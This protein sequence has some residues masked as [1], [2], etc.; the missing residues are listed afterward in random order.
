VLFATFRR[1]ICS[2]AAGSAVWAL[3]HDR[4]VAR[5]AS[6]I[7]IGE[8]GGPHRA[9]EFSWSANEWSLHR[10]TWPA[11]LVVVA[12]VRW[13]ARR[14]AANV[15]DLRF[16]FSIGTAAFTEFAFTGVAARKGFGLIR[17][18][19][20][21]GGADFIDRATIDEA[22]STIRA[23]ATIAAAAIAKIAATLSVLGTLVPIGGSLELDRWPAATIGNR[24]CFE[25][26]QYSGA[27]A[28]FDKSKSRTV[29]VACEPHAIRQRLPA[30]GWNV[31]AVF[32]VAIVENIGFQAQIHRWI[33]VGD[34]RKFDALCVG[35]R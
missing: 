11:D 6:A 20:I 35:L 4:A 1:T 17:I 27:F 19:R 3:P 14:T 18:L 10:H 33:Y 31:L 12:G 5:G 2:G 34:K 30:R 28:A 8:A 9:R 22:R 21:Y 7:S 29:G 32:D 24:A 16:T 13:A 25:L 15:A 26:S 23:H